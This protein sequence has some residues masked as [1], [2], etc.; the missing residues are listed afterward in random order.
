M[1]FLYKLKNYNKLYSNG[2]IIKGLYQ[3]NFSNIIY[4]FIDLS[5]MIIPCEQVDIFS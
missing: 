2:L 3:N 5:K 1:Y 4:I